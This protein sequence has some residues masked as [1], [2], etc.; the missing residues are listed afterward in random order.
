MGKV[1]YYRTLLLLLMGGLLFF[2]ANSV[3]AE[4]ISA[5]AY[6]VVDVISQKTILEK[7]S[8]K[9]Y[10]IASVVKL[11]N[12]VV[13]LEHVSKKTT[14]RLTKAM[15][16]PE[17][18]SPS[19]FLNSK[20]S[21]GN[22]LKASL[23]QSVNDA[24]QALSYAVGIGRFVNLMNKKAKAL[25]MQQT[26]YY[27]AHGLNSKNK[28]TAADLAK[29]L[30]HIYQK[31]PEILEVTKDDNFW[32]PNAEGRL[33]KFKNVNDFYSM[34]NF[35]GGKTGYL[36]EAKKT[37]ASVFSINGKPVIVVVLY[38]DNAKMD[39]LKLV[40]LATAAEGSQP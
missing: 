40:E 39:T 1:K 13:T 5:G 20:I 25:N 38:S 33:L 11:M 31:R 30:T 17:G 7:D 14:V 22:L 23:T 4:E 26:V 18:H 9:Q 2:M 3:F 6:L 37:M 29:L 12:A 36:V 24:S 32:L 28:S 10:S 27:D 34:P 19:L 15:L 16:K 35:I 8:Q 21:V